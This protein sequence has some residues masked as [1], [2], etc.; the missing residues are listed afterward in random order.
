M[1]KYLLW[2][3]L[4]H[5]AD[6]SNLTL[7]GGPTQGSSNPWAADGSCRSVPVTNCTNEP[8]PDL[9][10]MWDF[11]SGEKSTGLKVPGSSTANDDWQIFETG[12]QTRDDE[13]PLFGRS[14]VTP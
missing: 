3:T 10:P 6:A 7:V 11:L 9:C 5:C 13:G 2:G 14:S 8:T 1:L 12:Q 4:V